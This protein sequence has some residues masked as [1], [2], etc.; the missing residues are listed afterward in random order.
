MRRQAVD[1]YVDRLLGRRRPKPFAAT[2]QELAL[3]RT[4]IDLAAAGPDATDPSPAFVDRLRREL[5]EHEQA[6]AAEPAPQP[7]WRTPPRRRLLAAGALTATGALAGAAA[8]QI[9]L[10]SDASPQAQ[11][12]SPSGELI[13]VTGAWQQVAH[14]AEVPE[15]A[16]VAFD[17]GA[18]AGFVRRTNGRVQAVS[19]DC[20]HQGCRLDLDTAHHVLACPCHG[21]TFNLAGVNLTHPRQSGEPLPTLPR[22]PVREIDGAIQIYAPEGDHSPESPQS[23][24]AST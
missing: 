6:A 5:R 12:P 9:F 1:R 13:P 21:A 11:Q 24:Q 18:V 16:V 10:R 17:L 15:G 14:T 4:A 19:G 20:T 7:A 22:L 8:D 23:P 3:V 2:E